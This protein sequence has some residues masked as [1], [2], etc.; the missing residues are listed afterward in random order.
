VAGARTRRSTV[1]IACVVATAAVL[2]VASGT[3]VS[4]LKTAGRIV[5]TP[6]SF[7]IGLVAHPVANLL[8]GAV[9]YSTVV[10]QNQQLRAEL[11]QAR[12]LAAQSAALERQLSQITAVQHLAFVGNVPTTIAQVTANSPTNFAATVTISAGRDEG[13]LTGMPVVAGGGLIGTVISSS[14][15]SSTVQLIT[16]QSSVV[17]CTFGNGT[18]NVLVYGRG[19]NNPLTV[20]S[21]TLSSALAP[22][23]VL[24]TNGLE[25]ASFP[26]G[27]PVATVTS[28]T[29]TPGASTWDLSLAPAADLHHLH[30]VD[31]MLWEPST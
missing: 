9:N 13:V 26:P 2:L 18:N 14:A 10:H 8:A 5:V 11:G 28:A 31:V 4:T 21:V 22:G 15:N 7:T 1:V 27:I 16:D 17:A 12:M 3:L 25:G 23:T 19:V 30:Y 6:F 20:S 29:L 24:S